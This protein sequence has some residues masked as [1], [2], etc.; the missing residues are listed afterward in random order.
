MYVIGASEN[1][2]KGILMNFIEKIC[3]KKRES[4]NIFEKGN[5]M[6]GGNKDALLS[7][8]DR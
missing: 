5:K 7:G 8:R 2:C 3:F 4:I 6:K 1:I